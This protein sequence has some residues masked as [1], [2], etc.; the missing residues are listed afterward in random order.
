MDMDNCVSSYS[1]NGDGI[2]VAAD[3]FDFERQ[4]CMTIGSNSIGMGQ[5]ET[6]LKFNIAEHNKIFSTFTHSA[7]VTQVKWQQN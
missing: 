6:T 3:N 7:R 2:G 1:I 4:Y 5:S